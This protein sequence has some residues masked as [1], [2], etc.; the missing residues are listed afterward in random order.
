MAFTIPKIRGLA[1]VCFALDRCLGR[2]IGRFF[3][4]HSFW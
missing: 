2:K 3:V 4:G 1:P